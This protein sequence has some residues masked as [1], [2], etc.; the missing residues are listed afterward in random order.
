LPKKGKVSINV[1]N[2]AGQRV[3]TLFDGTQ[4]AGWHSIKW[5]GRDKK[6]QRIGSGIYF[7]RIK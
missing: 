2:I 3:I 6:G 1:Y 7:Y 5:N 4:S